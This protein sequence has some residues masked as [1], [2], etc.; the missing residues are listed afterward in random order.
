MEEWLDN[1]YIFM[2]STHNE[3]KSEIAER[4]IKMFK[5]KIYKT[6][7]LLIANL[8]LV[9]YLNKLVDQYNN[10]CDHSI[11]KKPINGGFSALSKKIKTNCIAPKFKVNDSAIITKYENIF[12]K[13][14]TKIRNI[15]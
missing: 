6:L 2:Y 13:S 3:G 11:N 1:D 7:Q 15:Y 4:F 8:I 9:S 12:S 14:S 10:N 5:A